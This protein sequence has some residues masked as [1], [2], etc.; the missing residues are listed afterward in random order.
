MAIHKVVAVQ[1]AKAGVFMK[2]TFGLHLGAILRDWE[3]VVNDPQSIMAQFPEDFALYEIASYDDVTGSFT[4]EP[5]P[6]QLSTA[7][8]VQKTKP[9]IPTLNTQKQ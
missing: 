8:Q 4:P 1:D 7:R 6:R 5:T 9:S 2:P 3:A